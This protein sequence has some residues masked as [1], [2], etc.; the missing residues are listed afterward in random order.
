MSRG[1]PSMTALLG[2]LAVA[3]FQN[4]DKIAEM[5]R[6]AGSSAPG[7]PDQIDQQGGLGGLLGNL[8]GSLGGAGQGD[9]QSGLGGLL[10]GL[11]SGGLGGLLG[12]GL[13]EL[14]DSFRQQ[15]QG[16]VAE[17]WVST[18]PNKP[19]APDQLEQAIGPEV[20][21]TLTQQTGLSRE[22]LLSRLTTMLPET[23]DK[24]TPDGRLPE[25]TDLPRS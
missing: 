14:M 12:G 13:G 22:E 25:S 18:G 5:L 20:L 6:G 16:D 17:S 23:V 11:G 19:I 9:P 21:A 4:R 3:G 8:G 24:V 1:F 7:N 15:G 2:L 10:G